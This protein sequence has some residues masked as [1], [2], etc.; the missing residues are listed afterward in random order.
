M[1]FNE[2]NIKKKECLYVYVK[3][4][5]KKDLKNRSHFYMR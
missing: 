4:Y 3:N 1:K 2:H 5:D